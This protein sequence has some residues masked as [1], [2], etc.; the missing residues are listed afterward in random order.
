MARGE[1][2]K[3]R[4]ITPKERI[5]KE[6]GALDVTVRLVK[7]FLL[8]MLIEPSN[9]LKVNE[10]VPCLPNWLKKPF[11]DEKS[12]QKNQRLCNTLSFRK[13]LAAE[14]ELLQRIASN[15]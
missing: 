3:S 11:F 2:Q 14:L 15:S 7:Q 9:Q 10:I 1:T 6:A 8:V 12:Q 4:H 13:K 5:M